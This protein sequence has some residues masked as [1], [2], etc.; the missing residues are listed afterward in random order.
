MFKKAAQR[1][2]NERKAEAYSLPYV[3]ALTGTH[4]LASCNG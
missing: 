3:E 4:C 1:G 2:R